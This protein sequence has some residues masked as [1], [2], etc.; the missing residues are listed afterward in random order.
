MTL[1]DRQRAARELLEVLDEFQPRGK[2]YRR[3][4]LRL[5]SDTV[6]EGLRWLLAEVER[7]EAERDALQ[8]E[9][10]RLKA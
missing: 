5:G 6:V 1:E 2:Y 3:A 4:S 8:R 9:V 7:L 10:E